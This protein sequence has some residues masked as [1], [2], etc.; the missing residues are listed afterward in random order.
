MRSTVH[1]SLDSFL[2]LPVFHDVKI[3][4]CGIDNF[5]SAAVLL[6]KWP[7]NDEVEAA[8]WH[9]VCAYLGQQLT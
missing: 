3:A 9:R 8:G 6:N 1:E 5:D 4:G 7:I 2:L